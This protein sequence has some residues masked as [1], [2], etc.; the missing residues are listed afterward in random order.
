MFRIYANCHSRVSGN[1]EACP[2]WPLD[3]G[4]PAGMTAVNGTVKGGVC[5]SP[6]VDVGCVLRPKTCLI[7]AAK[8]HEENPEELIQIQQPSQSLK[9]VSDP[10]GT[11]FSYNFLICISIYA[12]LRPF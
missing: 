5:V 3:S 1:P 12:T 6:D 9:K 4:V 2:P 8:L 11:N 7:S 10:N